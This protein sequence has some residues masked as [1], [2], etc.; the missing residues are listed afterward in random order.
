MKRI[1]LVAL[2]ALA[3]RS[4]SEGTNIK[5]FGECIVGDPGSACAQDLF[6]DPSKSSRGEVL[7]G[8]TYVL[9]GACVKKKAVGEACDVN[10]PG[11]CQS[12][13]VCASDGLD[14]QHGKCTVPTKT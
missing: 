14:M 5:E 12:P 6:C 13:A 3:C 10:A 1:A 2:I 9:Y 8:S 7:K 4:H 11:A